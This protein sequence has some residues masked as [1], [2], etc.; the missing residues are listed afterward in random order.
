M[1]ILK[2]RRKGGR[3]HQFDL[4]PPRYILEYCDILFGNFSNLRKEKLQNITLFYEWNIGRL[5]SSRTIV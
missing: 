3:G 2:K 5:S 4:S 1:N